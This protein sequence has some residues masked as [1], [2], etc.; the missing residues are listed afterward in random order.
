MNACAQHTIANIGLHGMSLKVGKLILPGM[1]VLLGGGVLGNGEGSIAEKVIKLPAKRTPDGIRTLLNDFKSESLEDEVFNDYFQR[2][3]KNYFY[4]LL[5]PL[6][7]ITE[8]TQDDLIDWGNEDQ[9]KTL[10]GVGECAG[11]L[12]DMV[13]IV[14][15]ETREKLEKADVAYRK[16]DWV[17]AIYYSYNVYINAG[18]AF[19]L[20]KDLTCNTHISV[21]NNFEKYL[22]DNT[23]FEYQGN[24]KENVMEI[25]QNAPDK[26]F[27]FVYFVE[28]Q[29]FYLRVLEYRNRQMA[30]SPTTS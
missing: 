23:D 24:F 25:N 8:V 10:I 6:S 2:K 30:G 29:A 22:A 7:E 28:A 18:K 15:D 26:S 1:Q 3:G 17:N 5:K 13:T 21:L 27:A 19:L 4:N 14:L 11:S 12:V 16:Q 20:S 9:Y